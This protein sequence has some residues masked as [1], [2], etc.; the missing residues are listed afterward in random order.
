MHT[1]SE[2]HMGRGLFLSGQPR[3][4]AKGAWSQRS[5]IL[6]VPFY[7]CATVCRRT[8]KF[9][10]TAHCGEMRASWGQPRLPSQEGGI[11]ALPNFGVLLYLYPHFLT[12]S[13]QIRLSN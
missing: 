2:T 1:P 3:T 6:G 7:L 5:P 11:P 10:V 9:D 12:Q 13:D 8:T 4:H